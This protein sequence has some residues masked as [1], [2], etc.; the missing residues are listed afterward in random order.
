MGFTDAISTFIT[1]SAAGLPG[2]LVT[3]LVAL[4]SKMPFVGKAFFYLV[5]FWGM[6][7]A[8]V[9]LH[10]AQRNGK[11][12]ATPIYVRTLSYVIVG[13]MMVFDVVFNVIL[14]SLIFFELPSTKALTFTARCE[15]HLDD[16]NFRGSIARWVC[17]GWLNP[18]ESGHC[19]K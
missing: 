9:A 11:L 12:A 7:L 15:L 13:I 4:A 1:S 5:F 17:N 10:A 18:F 8:Y 16:T 2:Q 3:F 6:F 19:H 14:G